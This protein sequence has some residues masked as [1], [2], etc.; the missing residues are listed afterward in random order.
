MFRISSNVGVVAA[1][2]FAAAIWICLKMDPNVPSWSD[3]K[4]SASQRLELLSG[5]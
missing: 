1:L 3:L 4:H 2:V 5:R